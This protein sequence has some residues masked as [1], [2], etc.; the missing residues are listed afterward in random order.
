MKHRLLLL[1]LCGC[2]ASRD[3]PD[4]GADG[5]AARTDR[6]DAGGSGVGVDRPLL[7]VSDIEV[8]LAPVDKGPTYASARCSGS[9]CWASASN[10]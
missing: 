3:H 9:A 7:H 8:A 5:G 1:L 2:P 10:R 6:A 4:A